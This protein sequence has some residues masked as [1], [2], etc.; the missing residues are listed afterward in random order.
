M[1]PR[2]QVVA[3]Q[4]HSQM[5]SENTQAQSNMHILVANNDNRSCLRNAQ[6]VDIIFTLE[7]I[8][9]KY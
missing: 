9:Y 7:I 3:W 5:A 8:S 2:N 1:G 6:F 4:F